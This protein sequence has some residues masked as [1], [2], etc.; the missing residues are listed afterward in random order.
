MQ[1]TEDN[2]ESKKE[3]M[4]KA[5]KGANLMI[6]ILAIVLFPLVFVV[7]F[8]TLAL[9]AV[10]SDTAEKIVERELNATEYAME[11]NLGNIP[12]DFHVEDGVL[13]KGDVNMKEQKE[14]L[15]SFKKQTGVDI[16]M[17]WGGELVCTSIDT[18]EI[19]LNSK[20]VNAAASGK[21]YFSPSVKIGGREYFVYS[22]PLYAEGGTMASGVMMTAIPV[23]ENEAIYKYIVTSNV[24]FMIILVLVFCGLTVFD[25][26]LITKALMGVVKNLDR[27]AEGELNFSIS[28]KLLGRSDEVGKIARA[29]HSVLVG[30]SKI[31]TNI[32]KSMKEMNEFTGQFTENFDTIGQSISNI[33]TAVNE[34]AEGA[35]KQASDTQRVS[36]SMNDM[37]EAL[38]K[39]ADSVNALTNSA[40]TM[41]KSNETV[42]ATLKELKDISARTS[43]SVDQVQKQTNL[44]N[45]SAQAIRAATDLIAGIA[46]QTNLLSLNASIE[47]ARA[48]E[49]GRGFAVVAEEI[50]GLAEQSRESADQI[51]GI[52]ETLIQNSNQ[53]VEIM[54][55]MVEEINQQN[56]KLGV[57]VNVFADLNHEVQQAVDAINIISEELD[58]I[59]EY[60][61]GVIEKIDGLSE[62]SQNNAASTEETAAT[63]DQLA[64]IVDDCRQTTGQL[65][66]IAD[67]L[68]E[69]ARKF[70]I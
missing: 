20:A 68:T 38:N 23:D 43:E 48:G 61:N 1:K 31:V 35:T 13:Y 55:S 17:L 65:N 69:N 56:E 52:V 11:L 66:R 53:S 59:E 25:V 50:R 10:G 16:A 70:Q 45:E 8:A 47:A 22:A 4:I 28:E 32:H 15:L 49:M 26:L 7:I 14:L 37:N 29:V 44:T 30:F 41:K 3:E 63:M 34:I 6:K 57:T 58:R 27:V 36:E 18:S 60:K 40:V 46:N 62:I 67:E 12:G 2:N 64:Q 54:D 19:K 9:N 33:N 39:T 24:I 51:R 42:D 21:E 5:K